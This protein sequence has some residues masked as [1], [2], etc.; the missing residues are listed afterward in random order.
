MIGL[1][2]KAGIASVEVSEKFGIVGIDNEKSQRKLAPKN[3]SLGCNGAEP[4]V[5]FLSLCFMG[6][7]FHLGTPEFQDECLEG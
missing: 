2:I 4:P 7:F 6:T 5:L 1:S 3:P